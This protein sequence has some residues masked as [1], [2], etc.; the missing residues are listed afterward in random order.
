MPRRIS[1][2]MTRSFP[3]VTS[4]RPLAAGRWVFPAWVFALL[5]LP[6]SSSFSS[7]P[8][9]VIGH[10][11]HILYGKVE[12]NCNS[13]SS[14]RVL[15]NSAWR[16]RLQRASLVREI[17]LRTRSMTTADA[18]V[19]NWSDRCGL[20]LKTETETNWYGSRRRMRSGEAIDRPTIFAVD[21]DTITDK[22]AAAAVAT[23]KLP[24]TF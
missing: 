23:A 14:Y 11:L 8:T 17:P 1:K 7:I 13:S 21:L 12:P 20:E 19:S 22:R 6:A 18:W 5:W 4:P 9:L 16:E 3:C 2:L 15:L 10:L 24:K